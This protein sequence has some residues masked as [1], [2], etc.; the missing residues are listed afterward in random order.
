MDIRTARKATDSA[1]RA[2]KAAGG[3]AAMARL[4]DVN[5]QT[6]YYWLKNGWPP[7]KCFALE[8]ACEGTVSRAD[9]RP[10]IYLG[11]A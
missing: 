3:V 1:K 11:G 4:F 5:R 10:D 2:V 7:A 6:I 8:A 9:I